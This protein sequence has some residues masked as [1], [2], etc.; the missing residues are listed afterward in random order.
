MS[1]SPQARTLLALFAVVPWIT[2]MQAAE[3]P[4]VE[5]D[6]QRLVFLVQYV[7]ADYGLAVADGRIIDAFEYDEMVRFSGLLVRSIDGLVARG[8]PETVGDGLRRLERAIRALRPWD[9]VRS[10]AD[11]LAAILLERLDLVPWPTT[12]PDPT[13]GGELYRTLCAS[14]H[15][16]T[17]RGDGPLAAGQDPPPTSFRDARMDLLSPHQIFGATR[18][19]IDGTAMASYAD[20]LSSSDTWDLAFHLLTLREDFAPAAAAPDVELSL[21][22]LVVSSN[23]ALL[24]RVGQDRRA[25][26]DYYRASPPA[27]A[28]PVLAGP[29]RDADSQAAAIDATAPL[30]LAL[31]LQDAFAGVA[32]RMLPSVANVTTYVRTGDRAAEAAPE[33][34][35]AWAV[36]GSAAL[37]YPGFRRLRSGSGFF[38]SRDGYLLTGHHVVVREDGEP[39]EVIDVELPGGRRVLSRLV[40]AEPTLDLALLKLEVVSEHRPP[41]VVPVAI[42]DA[43]SLRVGH[44]VIAVGDP[45]G[46]ER[47]YAVGTLAARAD[48]QCYQE[49]RSATLL[50]ASLVLHRESYG[51]PLVDIRGR[52]VGMLVPPPEAAATNATE[53]ALP[54]ELAINISD[55]LKVVESRRSPW[56]GVSVLELASARRSRAAEATPPDLPPTGV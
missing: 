11:D 51:G 2:P 42:G 13:R 8:A 35:E 5:T 21:A 50:Q 24:A 1:R 52:V 10:L 14:C 46:P 49:Q 30:D 54:I 44:W 20:L 32:E 33:R 16:E 22:E 43:G 45:S 23:A 36:A 56:L 19:G 40:G 26:V 12:A 27:P 47:T 29:R 39:A 41:E 53:Y 31:Q 38:V 34:D 7:G 3:P 17:G 55:A 9:E 4:A 37:A 28:A 25:A 15:G 48:R 6:A 18:F